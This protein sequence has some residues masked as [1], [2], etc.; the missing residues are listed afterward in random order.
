MQ[1]DTNLE[2]KYFRR[3]SG[4]RPKREG[5]QE[6]KRSLSFMNYTDMNK[7]QRF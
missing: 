1:I 7:L 3:R 2:G 5:V 6:N 4:E